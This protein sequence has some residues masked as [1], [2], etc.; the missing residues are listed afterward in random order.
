VHNILCNTIHTLLLMGLS[1]VLYIIIN[2]SKR[3]DVGC[4]ELSCN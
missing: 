1:A 2:I 3:H 4:I